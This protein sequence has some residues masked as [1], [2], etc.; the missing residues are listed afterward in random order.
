LHLSDDKLDAANEQLIDAV[1]ATGE[2]FLSHTRLRGRL[3]LRV[4]IGHLK[5]AERHVARVWELLTSTAAD[6]R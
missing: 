5:T 6:L 2:V 4:A 1:N 3:A